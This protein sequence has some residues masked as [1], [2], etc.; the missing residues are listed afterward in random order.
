MKII[1]PQTYSFLLLALIITSCLSKPEVVQEPKILQDFIENGSKSILP[2]FSYAGYAY[3]E[4]SIPTIEE[5]IFHVS[6]FGAVVNDNIDDSRAIQDAVDAAG[7]AGGGIVLFSAGTYD[8]NSDTTKNDIIRINY[9]NVVLRGAGTD[10][11][12]TIIHSHSHTTQAEENSP[13]LSQFVFHSGLALQNSDHFFNI[14]ALPVYS[15]LSADAAKGDRILKLDKT[16][17][18]NSGDILVVAMR[19]TT[20]DGDLINHLMSPLKFDHFM[21]SYL[22]A[23]KNR[24]PSFQYFLEIDE[25]LSATEVQMKQPM[26]RAIL[27]QFD[28]FVTK[29]PMLKNVGIENFRFECD[30]K[31]GYKHHL[32]REHDYGWG[33]VCLQR[34]AHGWIRNIHINNYV[35]TTHL[36]N[37]RNVSISD[38]TLTGLDG[39]YGPK[40]YHSSDNLVYNIDVRA[41]YTHGP[42]LE[43]CCYGNVYRKIN[44][45][46]KVP[47]DLHGIGGED[48]SPPAYNL[49]E[50][51]TNL[52]RLAG[53]GAPANIPHASEYNTFWG[54]EMAGYDDD[55]YNELFF[56]WIWRD[57]ER[58]KNEF[59]IDCHKQ[60]LRS[61]MVGI[62]HPEKTLSIEHST[63][64]RADD[65]IYVEG[66]NINMDLPSLYETQLELRLNRK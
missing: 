57:A 47:V 22:E 54:L 25:V 58:F 42:G 45:A 51:C 14:D 7:K 53:G 32:N 30:Y 60:Y 21:S 9:S 48:F 46:H 33:A 24:R 26:R 36:V 39:H 52:F 56:S 4:K 55:T 27:K 28:A 41:L 12:G 50:D 59:H 17:G 11:D 40:M 10:I 61:I 2:D 13:W 15:K 37:S 3:G 18:L 63:E 35:Q 8:L 38:I 6:D 23:G 16:I 64:D 20:D 29:V 62:H 19:N 49:Y 43:G 1:K 5:P 31:G 44:H 34:V 66:L 65:W